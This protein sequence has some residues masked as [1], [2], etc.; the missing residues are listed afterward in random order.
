MRWILPLVL[1]IADQLSSCKLHIKLLRAGVIMPC[2]LT[3]SAVHVGILLMLIRVTKQDCT[4]IQ[5]LMKVMA[6]L[7]RTIL[8]HVF[9]LWAKCT[10]T[11]EL[12]SLEVWRI[13]W[14]LVE[15][16]TV[17]NDS[18]RKVFWTFHIPSLPLLP[19]CFHFDRLKAKVYLT[20]VLTQPLV[21]VP[22]YL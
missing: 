19:V 21:A 13:L 3:C 15:L 22:L 11:K 4:Q 10:Q 16:Y 17:Q 18:S 9:G 20:Y 14:K 2:H 1:S 12:F 8:Y 5:I 6:E 7:Q